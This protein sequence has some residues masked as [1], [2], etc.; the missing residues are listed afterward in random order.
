MRHAVLRLNR[1]GNQTR[2]VLLAVGLGRFFIIGIRGV[3]ANLLREFAI[4]VGNETPDMFLIDIQRDQVAGLA[5]VS[6]ASAPGARR[7]CSRCF[8]RGSRR[9]AARR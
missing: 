4:D 6:R 2:V 7:A 1:P 8:A 5:A 3:Q 9:C